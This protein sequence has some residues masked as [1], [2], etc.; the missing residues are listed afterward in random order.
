MIPNYIYELL[1]YNEDHSLQTF[2]GRHSHSRHFEITYRTNARPFGLLVNEQA[3][4]Y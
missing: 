2:S 1:A 3:A 4:R